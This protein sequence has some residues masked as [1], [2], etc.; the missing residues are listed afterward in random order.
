MAK[1]QKAVSGYQNFDIDYNSIG[2]KGLNHLL[3]GH[4]QNLTTIYLCMEV[5]M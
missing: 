2:D 4:F 3:S 1:P 5:A